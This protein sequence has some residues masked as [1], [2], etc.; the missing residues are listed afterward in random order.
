MNTLQTPDIY[1]PGYEIIFLQTCSSKVNLY[2]TK[3]NK[4]IIK[5]FFYTDNV[6]DNERIKKISEISSALS[7]LIPTYVPKIYSKYK[8]DKYLALVMENINGIKLYDLIK[9]KKLNATN[10]LKVIGSLLSALNEM[11]CNGYVHND[12]H[13]GNIIVSSNYNVK[14]IDFE[15]TDNIDSL[16]DYDKTTLKNDDLL[17]LKCHIARLI[18][19]HLPD[20]YLAKIIEITKNYNVTDVIEY[21]INPNLANDLYKIFKCFNFINCDN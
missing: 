19:P 10:T 9:E 17:F 2:I 4:H 12:L 18:F 13:G 6:Y 1:I 16:C 5:I 3:D 11:H 7:N 20:T 14:I 15:E 8:T 21:D